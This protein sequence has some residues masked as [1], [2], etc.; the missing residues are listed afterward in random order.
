MFGSVSDV[1][2]FWKTERDRLIMHRNFAANITIP[3][4]TPE[5][6]FLDKPAEP[7]KRDFDPAEFLHTIEPQQTK[8]GRPSEIE[9]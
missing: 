1:S 5:E 7:F 6:Y 4:H 8:E 9:Y 3:F 2:E